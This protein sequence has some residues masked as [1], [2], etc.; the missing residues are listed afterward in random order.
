M[1]HLGKDVS[2]TIENSTSQKENEL[3]RLSSAK[4]RQELGWSSVWD[5]DTSL[6]YIAL[7]HSSWLNGENLCDVTLQQIREYSDALESR[8]ENRYD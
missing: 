8:K 4:A 1:K 5:I 2:I 3:L 6:E 7:W